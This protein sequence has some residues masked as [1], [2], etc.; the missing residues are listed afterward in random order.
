MKYSASIF[1]TAMLFAC[2]S[3]DRQTGISEPLI[4]VDKDIHE[5]E[6]QSP[7]KHDYLMETGDSIEIPEF[8]VSIDLSDNAEQKLASDHESI[9]VM[10]FFTGIPLD[11]IPAKHKDKLDADELF[12]RSYS[13]EL[14]DKR[15][16]IFKGIKFHKELYSLLADTDIDL[17]INVY[18]GRRAGP[19]N[20]LSCDILQ[21]KMSNVAGKTFTLTGKLINE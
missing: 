16:A 20:I 3:P 15:T 18:S 4:Q 21:D 19:Y 6:I 12:L 17:L 1:M 8:E 2:S 9:I 7:F 5:Q 11:K 14:T 10:A 13:V